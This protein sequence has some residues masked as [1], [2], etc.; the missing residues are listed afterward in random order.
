MKLNVL[1]GWL[2]SDLV[3]VDVVPAGHSRRSIPAPPS[4]RSRA[5]LLPVMA[6]GVSSF[7]ACFLHCIFHFNTICLT[8]MQHTA[9]NRYLCH[10]CGFLSKI[11][12]YAQ[13]GIVVSQNKQLHRCR[14]CIVAECELYMMGVWQTE[15]F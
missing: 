4:R 1:A 5:C 13:C 10:G 9:A 3:D 12:K 2:W 8:C 14:V 15:Y 7:P 6:E 11:M